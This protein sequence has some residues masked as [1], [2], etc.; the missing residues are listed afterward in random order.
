M[1]ALL[2]SI[3]NT[4]VLMSLP[5]VIVQYI[6]LYGLGLTSKIYLN[7]VRTPFNIYSHFNGFFT[8][9]LLASN[10]YR[11]ITGSDRVC[12]LAEAPRISAKEMEM[13]LQDIFHHHI[14]L[15]ALESND[16]ANMVSART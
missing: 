5:L 7:A 4:I 13:A 10:G 2:T 6:A 3:V 15:G 12:K 14:N 16:I 11:G 8:R 9:T 1:N